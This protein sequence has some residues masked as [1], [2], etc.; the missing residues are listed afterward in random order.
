MTEEK[1]NWTL[2]PHQI[3][4]L[5]HL[6]NN[7][8]GGDLSDPGVGK[9]APMCVY[10]MWL[11]REYD[12]KTIWTMP[13]SLMYK[14]KEELMQ[15]TGLLKHEVMIIDGP[16]KV[17][18]ALMRFPNVKVFIMGFQRFAED[19]ET[20]KR[21]HPNTSCVIVDEFQMGFKNDKSKRTQSLYRAFHPQHGD[22]Q[23]F[24]VMS[25]TLIAGRLDTAYPAIR[26]IEPRYYMNHNDFLR[27][28]AYLDQWG[29]PYAWV[30]H[31]KLGR[32]FMTHFYRKSFEAVYGNQ[33]PVV[34]HELC[35][36]SE[37]QRKLYDKFEEK[38]ILECGEEFLTAVTGGAHVMRLRQ[39]MAHPHWFGLVEE[40][41]KTAKE[42]LLEVHFEDHLRTGKPLIVYAALQPEQE[43]IYKLAQAAGLRA[44]L[45]NGTVSNAKRGEIDVDFQNGKYDVLVG[46]PAT[47]TVGFNWGHVDHIVCASLDYQDD[48]FKQAIRR[49]IRGKREIPLRVTILEYADSIDQRIFNTVNAKS[50]EAE[51]VDNSYKALN[52][53]TKNQGK[54]AEAQQAE[55]SAKERLP[56]GAHSFLN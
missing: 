26:I 5:A 49:A 34:I 23:F 17:R 10:M 8:K 31:E 1:K 41:E 46:S 32:I 38:A 44:A 16:P 9:T 54:V 29:N 25:G 28:H 40:K 11:L 14:N 22:F 56:V 52:L 21:Y 51:K 2:R 19:W 15:W 18:D 7:P 39:L 12:V 48:N 4:S 43:R 33:D 50:R 55:V 13:K 37:K 20:V 36:M 27:Q 6:M 3:E 30:N 53:G 47:A 45:I 42:E 35:E 24:Q